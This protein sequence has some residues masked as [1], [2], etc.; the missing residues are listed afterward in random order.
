MALIG[1]PRRQPG[2]FSAFVPA[3]FPPKD[4]LDWTDPDLVYLL[5][6]ADLAVGGLGDIAKL[7]PDVDFFIYMYVKKEAALSSQIEGTQATLIDLVEAEAE[8]P[9]D[10][11]SD[12]DEIL[13]YIAAMNHGLARLRTLPLSLRYVKEL[14]REL[15]RGVRGE[16]RAPGEFRRT[17]NW[18]GGSSIATASFVPPAVP[19]M[20]RALADLEAFMHAKDKLPV[21][22]KAGL[23]HAQFETIHP[24][25]DGNGRTGRLLI[26]LYLCDAGVLP[27]PLL[28]LSEFFKRHRR[29]YYDKL[30]AYGSTEDGPTEWLKFFL[31]GVAEVAGEALR[32]AKKITELRE[33][34]LHAVMGF[35][36]TARTAK[37]LLDSLYARPVVTVKSVQEVTGLGS[38][39]AAA[40]LLERF[41]K[42]RILREM[43]G[44]ARH[45]R[46]IYDGYVKL[47]S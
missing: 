23:L 47:F 15:L 41:A 10:R 3:P 9:D 22:V 38:P 13:N 4:L 33:R 42:A 25:L 39:T 43:T 20:E 6:R 8:I 35:G 34:H 16:H 24:F 14:H 45:R 40:G 7:V 17:Q 5:S 29:A 32:V 36:K 19:D 27:L 11:P 12:V 46:Y 2:A 18:I 28:Y 37:L 21:L 30:S 26:S 31:E 44:R 1:T